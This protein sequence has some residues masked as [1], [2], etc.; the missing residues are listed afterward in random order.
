[1]TSSFASFLIDM[2]KASKQE[3]MQPRATYSAVKDRRRLNGDRAKHFSASARVFSGIEPITEKVL[4][5]KY[6]SGSRSGK[7]RLVN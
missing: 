7:V 4:Y 5:V 6:L 2:A 1:M 3:K